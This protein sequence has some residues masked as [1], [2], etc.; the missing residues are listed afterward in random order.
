MNLTAVE[1]E[2]QH[3]LGCAWGRFGLQSDPDE[4]QDLHW[5]GNSSQSPVITISHLPIL[6]G[7]RPA[8]TRSVVGV[9]IRN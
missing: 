7:L 5:G 4:G 6:Q 3:C 1:A 2:R 8:K 9:T